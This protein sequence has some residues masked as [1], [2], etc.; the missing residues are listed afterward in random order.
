MTLQSIQNT[1]ICHHSIA[2]QIGFLLHLG[3]W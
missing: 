2:N 1:T 3:S